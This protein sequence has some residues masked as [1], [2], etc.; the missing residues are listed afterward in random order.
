MRRRQPAPGP[1]LLDLTLTDLRG[2]PS[3]PS[4]NVGL[5]ELLV[6]QDLLEE[7]AARPPTSSSPGHMTE[8]GP[9]GARDVETV[10]R[11]GPAARSRAHRLGASLRHGEPP[12]ELSASGARDRGP[13]TA[14][15]MAQV[16][17]SSS[18]SSWPRTSSAVHGVRAA[19]PRPHDG[20][21]PRAPRSVQL[22]P[23]AWISG[24]A[25]RRLRTLRAQ[26][27]RARSRCV[28]LGSEPQAEP[29]QGA[30]TGVPPALGGLPGRPLSPVRRQRASSRLRRPTHA[31]TVAILRAAYRSQTAG[32]PSATRCRSTCRPTASWSRCRSRRDPR[33]QLTSERCWVYRLERFLQR[34]L[35]PPDTPARGLT[36]L[37]DLPAASRLSPSCGRQPG[38]PPP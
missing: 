19:A 30:A 6:R 11:P 32:V 33:R 24:L 29:G 37:H 34:V 1:D 27:P 4:K 10:T 28:R 31:V 15:T 18:P 38:W 3:R 16:L 25:H 21:D 9:I 13:G 23:D 12:R 35:R 2:A 5:A 36:R 20:A 14:R 17:T 22:P 26:R 7:H 8:G